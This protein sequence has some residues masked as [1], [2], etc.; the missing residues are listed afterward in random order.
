MGTVIRMSDRNP[1]SVKHGK[2]LRAQGM[3][4]WR[5]HAGMWLCSV[6][7]AGSLVWFLSHNKK[8]SK[9]IDRDLAKHI[10]SSL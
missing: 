3:R 4:A 7:S 1:D 8:K 2:Y 10:L 5:V 6:W 9:V